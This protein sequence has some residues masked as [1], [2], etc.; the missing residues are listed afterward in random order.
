MDTHYRRV[1][2]GPGRRTRAT[3]KT[4]VVPNMQSI[5]NIP[6]FPHISHSD[7][8]YDMGGIAEYVTHFVAVIMG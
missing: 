3:E 7:A 4:Q 2:Q 1:L 8:A 6:G 5:S